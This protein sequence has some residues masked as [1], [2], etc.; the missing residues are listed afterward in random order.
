MKKTQIVL[1]ILIAVVVGTFIAT[2]TGAN[3]SVA[4][5]EAFANPGKEYKVSGTLNRD[6]PV[7][8]DPQTNSELTVFHMFDKEG[9]SQMGNLKK[10]KPT[11][12][13]QSESIDLY[14]RVIDGEFVA[15]E[16]L[17][18]CPSKYN[19]NKHNLETAEVEN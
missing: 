3:T 11:G 9:N 4:F 15:T 14:G 10:A 6:Y 8:Y 13:E 12:L 16:M 17:M 18:K 19:K 5:E 2:F 7:P 1:I